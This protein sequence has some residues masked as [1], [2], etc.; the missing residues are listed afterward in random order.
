MHK[1][2]G[3]YFLEWDPRAERDVDELRVFDARQIVAAIGDLQYEAETR[4][5][6]RK[7]LR[8][9][10]PSVP[11]ASWEV[12]VGEYRVFY[13]VRKDQTVRVLRVILKGRR[14]TDEAAG[15]NDGE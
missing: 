13:E 15:S 10:I 14:T 11:D 8:N 9:V 12:R 1:A 6:Q 2:G 5:R 3:R 4:T 7:P